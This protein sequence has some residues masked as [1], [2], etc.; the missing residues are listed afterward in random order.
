MLIWLKG[1]LSNF[2]RRFKFIKVKVVF[3]SIY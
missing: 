2:H 3:I 1:Y